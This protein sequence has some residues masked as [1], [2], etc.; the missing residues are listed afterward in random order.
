VYVS[1]KPNQALY[2]EHSTNDY[3][4]NGFF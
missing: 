2:S 1:A 4:L 3:S